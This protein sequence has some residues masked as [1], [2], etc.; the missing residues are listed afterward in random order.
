MSESKNSNS[1]KKVIL[2]NDDTIA[3]FLTYHELH[4]LMGVMDG[5]SGCD[6]DADLTDPKDPNYTSEYAA[7]DDKLTFAAKGVFYNDV[8]KRKINPQDLI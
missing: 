3:V 7:I 1:D 4:L 5:S 8:Y 2:I 6:K